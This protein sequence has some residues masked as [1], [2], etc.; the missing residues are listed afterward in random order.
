MRA[1]SPT[2]RAKSR[3][4]STAGPSPTAPISGSTF[5]PSS[6]GWS[7]SVSTTAAGTA[8]GS[9]AR[10]AR[11]SHST[12]NVLE[13]LLEY[14]R[15]T[16]GTPRSREARRSGEEYLL[17][18]N[19]FRR[20]STGEPA[21]ERF[22]SFLHPNRWRYDVLRALD[23]FRSAA[24][25]DRRRSRSAT[26][27]GY[28]PRSFQALGGRHLAPRLE[29]DRTGVVRGRRRAGQAVAVGDSPGDAGAQM[30]GALAPIGTNAGR[31]RER[32]SR[33]RRSVRSMRLPLELV[34]R[35]VQHLVHRLP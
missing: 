29:P 12:I 8:S 4:A 34:D 35:V 26:R 10:S 6:T 7:A 3:S 13:G 33:A 2:G 11:H 5:R 28:R 22:L 15:A 1:A 31:A 18:R 23:Y 25:L 14:E 20:L 24:M 16:G 19:L 27:R 21:D 17:E 9:T 30:V 32:R